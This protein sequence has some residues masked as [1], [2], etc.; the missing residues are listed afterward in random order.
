MIWGIYREYCLLVFGPLSKSKLRC[1]KLQTFSESVEEPEAE[2]A[3]A[4]GKVSFF[5]VLHWHFVWFCWLTI[6]R[7]SKD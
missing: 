2:Q 4:D 5:L 6:I 1:F 7:M 3:S